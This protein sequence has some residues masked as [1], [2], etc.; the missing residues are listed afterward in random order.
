MSDLKYE[1]KKSIG[2]IGEGTKGWKKEVNLVSWNERKPKLDIR[3]WDENHEKMG[4]G[5]T[6]SRS[7]VEELK[8]LLVAFDPEE[9]E[10]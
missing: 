7:E 9:M 4:R 5:I 2:V 6:L 1:I 8:K 3:D 10:A